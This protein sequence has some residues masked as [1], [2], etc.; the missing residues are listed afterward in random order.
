[1]PDNGSA[2]DRLDGIDM[3]VRS[4]ERKTLCVVIDREGRVCVRAPLRMPLETI[5]RFIDSRR[6]WIGHKKSAALER[7]AQIPV[8]NFTEGEQFLFKGQLYPLRFRPDAA[9]PIV[10]DRAFII[11]ENYRR[12]ARGMLIGWYEN[13]AHQMIEERV[14]V[15]A[16]AFSIEYTDLKVRD[17][18][19]QW[20][21][22]TADGRLCFSWRLVMCPTRIID[23][24][25]AHELAH[26]RHM[27][28]SPEFWA[29]VSCMRPD[30][31]EQQQWLKD[32]SPLLR[33]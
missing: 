27:N 16:D 13:K 31:K 25:V 3:F 4:P 22:C 17:T 26:R 6:E 21:S 20:G 33:F 19:S 30:Y 24:V 12:R 18:R 1:M 11:H 28:H 9:A 5:R 23:Y 7:L 29:L 15:Y 8:K 10:F 2:G 14:K 32:N